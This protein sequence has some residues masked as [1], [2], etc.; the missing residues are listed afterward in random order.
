MHE[1]WP[2]LYYSNL[3]ANFA[4]EILGRRARTRADFADAAWVQEVINAVERSHHERG[5]VGLPLDTANHRSPSGWPRAAPRA[6]AA[7]PCGAAEA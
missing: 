1:P 5:W 6:G 7:R 2:T 3:T 4:D